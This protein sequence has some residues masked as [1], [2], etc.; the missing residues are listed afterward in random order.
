[1]GALPSSSLP[2]H[3]SLRQRVGAALD[4]CQEAVDIEFKGSASW[5]T[6]RCK[7]AKTAMAMANLR[8]GGILVVGVS[9]ENGAWKTSGIEPGHLQSYDPDVIL[10]FVNSYASPD[11]QL[12]IVRHQVDD[13][14]TFLCIGV[15]EFDDLPIVCKKSGDEKIEVGAVYIRS[16]NAPGTTRV[17]NAAQMRDLLSLAA[18]RIARR[19]LET[20]HRVG[21]RPATSDANQ[22][23]QELGDL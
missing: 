6:L 18:E 7:I 23:D 4:R 15:H 20:A 14:P 9:E 11:I 13:G 5:N 19:L 16:T 3:A 22:F 2:G 12:D 8:D 1:L 21:L 10:G 17:T